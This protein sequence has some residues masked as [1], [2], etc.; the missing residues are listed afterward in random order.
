MNVMI[1]FEVG[2]NQEEVRQALVAKGY[3]SS[4]QVKRGRDILTFHLPSNALWKKGEHTSPASAKEDLTKSAKKLNTKVV[5]AVTMV[6]SK[7]DG[8]TGSPVSS[9]TTASIAETAETSS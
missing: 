4:W 8:L 7:W 1:C 2:S 3:L 6:I 5:R 9:D